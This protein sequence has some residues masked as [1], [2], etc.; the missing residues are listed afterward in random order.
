MSNIEDRAKLLLGW[1]EKEIAE[2]LT[3]HHH[4]ETM[5]W[6]ATAL[7]LGGAAYVIMNRLRP[8]FFTLCFGLLVVL[9]APADAVDR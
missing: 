7:F 4:K 5:A 9:I 1:L 2:E 8:W 3:Y 6:T